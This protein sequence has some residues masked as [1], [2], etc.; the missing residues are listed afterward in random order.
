[1]IKVIVCGV[2]GTKI[3]K[4]VHNQKYCSPCGAGRRKGKDQIPK[5]RKHKQ[6]RHKEQAYLGLALKLLADCKTLKDRDPCGYANCCGVRA[7]CPQASLPAPDNLRLTR[8]AHGLT[9]KYV[10]R[11]L[12]CSRTWIRKIERERYKGPCKDEWE[13]KIKNSI[14]KGNIT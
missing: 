10:S 2:C 3:R 9:V 8:L 4:K 1:M 11:E 13:E 6:Y 5:T 14:N 12:N 7:V